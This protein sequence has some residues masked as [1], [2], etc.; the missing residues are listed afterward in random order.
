MMQGG[1]L[2]KGIDI[3]NK[4]YSHE[5]LARKLRHILQKAD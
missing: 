1:M 2:D 5:E 4:P 3:L